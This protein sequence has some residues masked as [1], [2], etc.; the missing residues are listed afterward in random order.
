M[1]YEGYYQRL[2]KNGHASNEDVYVAVEKEKWACPYCKD[3]LAW[4]NSVDLTNGSFEDGKRID[5]YIE[6]KIKVPAVVC[7]CKSCK[8]AH[9]TEPPRYVI[10]KT[11]RVK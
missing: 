5:G 3:V 8:N 7:V 9:V 4:E 11:K 1:S 10:P 6:L 2:C